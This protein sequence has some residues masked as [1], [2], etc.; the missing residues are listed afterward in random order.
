MALTRVHTC[1]KA[2]DVA[3]LLPLHNSGNIPYH[4]EYVSASMLS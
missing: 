2:A 4:A 1:A 3:E